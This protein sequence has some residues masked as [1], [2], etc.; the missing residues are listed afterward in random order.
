MAEWKHKDLL[1]IESLC[2]DDIETILDLAGSCKQIYKRQI[3]KFPTPRGNFL[4]CLL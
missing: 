4:I 2:S 3:K 1:G